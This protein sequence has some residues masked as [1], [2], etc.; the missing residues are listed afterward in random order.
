MEE[1]GLGAYLPGP[2][3]TQAGFL[4]ISALSPVCR[5]G[6]TVGLRTRGSFWEGRGPVRCRFKI[7]GS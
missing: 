6:A 3:Q 1:L 4:L 2:Q 7:S 5:L